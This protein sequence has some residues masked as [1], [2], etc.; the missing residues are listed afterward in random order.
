[1]VSTT[2][3]NS[4][5]KLTRYTTSCFNMPDIVVLQDNETRKEVTLLIIGHGIAV[6]ETLDSP[7]EKAEK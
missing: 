4:R 1:L 5:F 6:V 2:T 7:A 3:S